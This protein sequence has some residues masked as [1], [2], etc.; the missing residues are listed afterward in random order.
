MTEWIDPY[1]GVTVF[2][3]VC[4]LTSF[5]VGYVIGMDANERKRKEEFTQ[6]F[7][8]SFVYNE[9]PGSSAQ[10]ENHYGEVVPNP[11]E[12]WR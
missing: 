1:L 10:I 12:D 8:P 2:I 9:P 5:I 3:F 6:N 11:S 4:V 7:K